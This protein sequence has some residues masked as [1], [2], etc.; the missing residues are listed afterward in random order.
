[1][2]ITIDAVF[3]NGIL[4]PLKPPP[5]PDGQRVR[6]TLEAIPSLTQQTAGM[7]KWTGDSEELQRFMEDPQFDLE[8][9]P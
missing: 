1:M 6:L 4:R 9:C 8:N 3:E 5:V 7:V 2:T